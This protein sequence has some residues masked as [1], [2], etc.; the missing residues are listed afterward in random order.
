[1]QVRYDTA[2]IGKFETDAQNGFLTIRDVPIATIGV[3]PYKLADGSV[4]MEAK[5]PQ[6]LLSDSTV[7]S[8][9]N[10]PVTDDH[11]P[12]MVTI[13][14]T[15][16]YMSGITSNN[17][18]VKGNTLRVDMVISDKDLINDI[19]KGKEELSIG[20]RTEVK[21]IAGDFEG[22]HYDSQQTNIQINHIAVVDRGRA[23]H[24]IRLTGDSASMLI[25]DKRTETKMDTE[26][27]RLDGRE[28]TVNSKDASFVKETDRKIYK[29]DAAEND[30][31]SKLKATIADLKKQ[32]AAAKSGKDDNG[33][34]KESE[35][36]KSKAKTDALEKELQDTKEKFSPENINKRVNNRV[37]LQ[38]DAAEY[39]AND[40]DFA[41]KSDRQ[42]KVD[43]IKTVKKDFDDKNVTDGRIDGL[44]EALSW[45]KN[46]ITGWRG[47]NRTNTT[48]VDKKDSEEQ[49][50]KDGYPEEYDELY[51]SFLGN[52]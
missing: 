1:M 21:N 36:A 11:P 49:E 22:E 27:V 19:S 34:D 20:F 13:D 25:Q 38:Q 35:L 28:I 14:N 39:L 46:S 32:L 8:A 12:E 16:K 44:F 26:I 6:E 51:D 15:K 17:A 50:R 40:Y 2:A 48:K 52:K 10:K 3:F 37:R 43:A 23:G 31:I 29:Q 24:S 4:R 47:G 18:H 33:K 41:D 7:E 9:N 45:N 42:I 5:L 30:E